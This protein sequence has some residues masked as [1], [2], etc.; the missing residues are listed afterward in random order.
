ME[1]EVS[2]KVEVE[3][4]DE[5]TGSVWLVVS[6]GRGKRSA[7]VGMPGKGSVWQAMGLRVF[8]EDK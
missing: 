1:E 5:E 6:F 2:R 3:L 7:R 8:T 4:E